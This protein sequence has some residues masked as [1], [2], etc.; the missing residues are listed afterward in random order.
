MV[1]FTNGKDERE[2]FYLKLLKSSMDDELLSDLRTNIAGVTGS[3]EMYE[4]SHVLQSQPQIRLTDK[5]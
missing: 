3:I 2:A 5:H 4:I 1:N